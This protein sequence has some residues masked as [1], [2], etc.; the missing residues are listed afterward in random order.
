MSRPAPLRLENVTFRYPTADTDALRDVSLVAP[1]GTVTWVFGRLGSGC[2]TLLQVAAGLAP[3]QTG[4]SL[5]GRIET[6]GVPQV[7]PDAERRLAGCIGYV[8]ASPGQQLSGIA[9]NVWEEVAF[10]PANLGWPLER[11]RSAV[12]DALER[13][14][15]GPLAARD[16]ATLSGGELQRVVIA[17]MAVI[18]PELWVLDEPASA[19]DFAHRDRLY[20]MIREE[21]N[22]GATVLI[23]SED[24]DALADVADQVVVLCEGR[25]ALEGEPRTVLAGEDVWD[26]GPGSTTAAALARAAAKQEPARFRPPYPV[27]IDEAVSRW[28]R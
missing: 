28:R 7:S 11:I 25:V 20:R 3:R 8:T 26:L 16:P 19:L 13:L 6:L 22:D 4:G 27:S 15:V 1:A 17:A 18:A 24:A 5:S 2:S 9:A 10:A 12:A 21:A 23:A 14:G